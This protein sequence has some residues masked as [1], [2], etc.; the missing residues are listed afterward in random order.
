MKFTSGLPETT[1]GFGSKMST[2][3]FMRPR[4]Q[5]LWDDLQ[6]KSLLD[7]PCGD[8]NWMKSMDLTG[9]NYK[10]VDISE[11]NLAKARSNA[12]NLDFSYLDIVK[13][14]LPWADM[15][16]CR[17]FH[18]HLPNFMVNLALHNFKSSGIPWLVATSFNHGSIPNVDIDRVG[19]FRTIN[20][21]IAP[22]N[23]PEPQWATEDPFGSGR[24][25]GL[26]HR[27]HIPWPSI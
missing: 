2:T 12:P 27:D 23:F 13:H 10:G 1:C 3:T 24:I 19:D 26:W 7:G 20:L 4:L 15:M 25:L 21:L 22:F 14:T 5:G 6:I 17:D 9:I 8:F 18:Q 16:L 11:S